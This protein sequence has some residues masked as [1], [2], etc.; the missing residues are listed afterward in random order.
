MGTML[1]IVEAQN[2]FIARAK[3]ATIPP[4][5]NALIRPEAR[6]NIIEVSRCYGRHNFI[7]IVFHP[8][9]SLVYN[10]LQS[11]LQFH[12]PF[13]FNLPPPTPNSFGTPRVISSSTAQMLL[14]EKKQTLRTVV[15]YTMYRI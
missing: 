15:Q 8:S 7:K 5:T 1:L 11:S 6:H 2:F 12:F 13:I 10:P 3:S 14:I 4:Y 9:F